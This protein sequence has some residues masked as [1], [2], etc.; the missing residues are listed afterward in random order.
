MRWTGLAAW[1]WRARTHLRLEARADEAYAAQ[2]AREFR[3]KAEAWSLARVR[4][5]EKEGRLGRGAKL[6][7]ELMALVDA[8]ELTLGAAANTGRLHFLLAWARVYAGM[9]EDGSAPM[10]GE[11]KGEIYDAFVERM[12][13][14][15]ADA[16][17]HGLTMQSC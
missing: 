5:D 9:M 14:R 17:R 6:F 8:A 1:R 10:G 3:R 7:G 11:L 2:L 12:R 15:E 4:G 16:R 13:E